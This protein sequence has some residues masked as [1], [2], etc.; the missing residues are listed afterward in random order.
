MGQDYK[1]SEKEQEKKMNPTIIYGFFGFVLSIIWALLLFTIGQSKKNHTN[2]LF[3]AVIYA[4]ILIG[5]IFS[6]KLMSPL[7][8]LVLIIERIAWGFTAKEAAGEDKFV[9]FVVILYF[10]LIGWLLYR[11]TKLG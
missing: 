8:F 7:M 3:Y 5:I 10:P 11:A 2:I 1:H 9:W 6:V 4:P